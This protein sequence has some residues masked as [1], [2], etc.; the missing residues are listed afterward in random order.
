MK[1]KKFFSAFLGFAIICSM[2]LSYVEASVPSAETTTEIISGADSQTNM[3]DITQKAMGS[4]SGNTIPLGKVK[5]S[6]SGNTILGKKANVR[7]VASDATMITLFPDDNFRKIVIDT[8]KG[9]ETTDFTNGIKPD[10]ED[11]NQQGKGQPLADALATFNG[12]INASGKGK[13]ESEKIKKAQGIEFLINADVNLF[14]NEIKDFSFLDDVFAVEIAAGRDTQKY[15]GSFGKNVTWNI[16]KN[17]YTILPSDFGGRLVIKQPA[18]TASVYDESGFRPR[19]YLRGVVPAKQVFNITR[20]QVKDNTSGQLRW[21]KIVENVNLVGPKILA[22]GKATNTSLPFSDVEKSGIQVIGIGIDQE[23]HYWTVDEIGTDTPGSQ[24]FKYYIHPQFFVYDTVTVDSVSTVELTKVDEDNPTEKLSGAE[25]TLFNKTTNTQISTGNTTGADGVLTFV[26]LPAGEYTLTETRAPENYEINATPLQFCVGAKL[27]GGLKTIVTTKDSDS[28][29]PSIEEDTTYTLDDPNKI[30]IAGPDV[31]LKTNVET[32]WGAGVTTHSPPVTLDAYGS[33]AMAVSVT[34]SSLQKLDEHGTNT[35]TNTNV[36][37]TFSSATAA[38]GDINAEQNH[39]AT[40][41]ALDGDFL[42]T[43]ITGPVTITIDQTGA[44]AIKLTHENKKKPSHLHTTSVKGEKVWVDNNNEKNTRPASIRVELYQDNSATP[45]R[46]A[47]ISEATGWAYSFTELPM[48][49][50]DNT[51]YTYT[52]KEANIPEGYTCTVRAD[53]KTITNTLTPEKPPV[54]PDE[55]GT[56][57]KPPVKPNEPGSPSDD[58]PTDNPGKP[59]TPTDLG[60]PP[61]SEGYQV[62]GTSPQTS[63]DAPIVLYTFLFLIAAGAAVFFWRK[64]SKSE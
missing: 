37:R 56:P 25:Y 13:S 36:G 11:E 23:I 34:Y 49:R 30:Y 26:D 12:E 2:T 50:A 4:L 18:T 16:G 45:Y 48:N 38:A 41:P 62:S 9:A 17:P 28:A 53:N 32:G 10:I 64:R 51:L 1:I 54:K 19:V 21:V 44:N 3:N 57:E 52:V 27:G 61:T 43:A 29:L 55:P 7:A 22:A 5:G 40:H 60:V 8:F 20:C 59:N 6:V 39:Q 24:S 63:D 58:P 46:T 15:F 42:A 31:P 47:D 33:T 14:D 35:E